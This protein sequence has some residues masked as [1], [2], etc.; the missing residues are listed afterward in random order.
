MRSNRK[1]GPERVLEVVAEHALGNFTRL[2]EVFALEELAA[3]VAAMQ[4]IPEAMK[5]CVLYAIACVSFNAAYTPGNGMHHAAVLLYQLLIAALVPLAPSVMERM[6]SRPPPAPP[7]T[8]CAVVKAS[9]AGA[10]S[11]NGVIPW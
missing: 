9:R 2:E 8:A 4:G 6:S 3:I 1:G 5:Q 10:L 7:H 11:I